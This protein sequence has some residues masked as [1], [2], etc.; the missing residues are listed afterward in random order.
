MRLLSRQL[1]LVALLFPP[2]VIRAQGQ[3]QLLPR[4]SVSEGVSA[5]FLAVAESASAAPQARA[6]WQARLDLARDALESVLEWFNRHDQ[7]NSS[8]RTLLALGPF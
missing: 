3:P 1:S 5:H 2:C 4:P 7:S 8:L 6:L